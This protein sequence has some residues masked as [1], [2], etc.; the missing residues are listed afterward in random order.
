MSAFTY[1][2]CAVF[3]ILNCLFPDFFSSV[4]V[5][6]NSDKIEQYLIQEQYLIHKFLFS[7]IT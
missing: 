5:N 6:T 2:V 1:H 4:S 3:Q 7:R